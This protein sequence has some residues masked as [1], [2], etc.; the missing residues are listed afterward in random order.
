MERFEPIRQ[1]IQDTDNLEYKDMFI[2]ENSTKQT[3]SQHFSHMLG[4]NDISEWEPYE[5]YY[6]F[7]NKKSDE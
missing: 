6:I 3:L 2:P 5:F 4:K 1:T 7:L